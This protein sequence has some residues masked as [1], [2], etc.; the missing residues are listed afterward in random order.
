MNCDQFIAIIIGFVGIL[1]TI[2]IAIS[3]R[4]IDDSVNWA[5]NRTRQNR[6]EHRKATNEFKFSVP[7]KDVSSFDR[8]ANSYCPYEENDDCHSDGDRE[9]EMKARELI[10]TRLEDLMNFKI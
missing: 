5:L 9:K 7:S 10:K 6:F 3:N 8:I 2:I 1:V 4:G